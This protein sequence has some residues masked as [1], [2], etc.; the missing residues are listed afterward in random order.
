M[1]R[2]HFISDEI[3]KENFG[4]LKYT[5]IDPVLD[6]KVICHHNVYGMQIQISSTS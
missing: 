4:V 2:V 6:F 3:L 5:A 1:P